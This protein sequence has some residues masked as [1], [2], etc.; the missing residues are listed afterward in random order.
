MATNRKPS[1]KS[2]SETVD[3]QRRRALLIVGYLQ[4]L[5]LPSMFNRELTEQDYGVWQKILAHYPINSIDYAFDNWGRNG[6][7]WPKVANI[8]ELIAAWFLSN[9]E[10]FKCCENCDFGWVRVFE[11]RTDGGKRVDPKVGAVKRCQCLVDWIAKKSQRQEIA[12]GAVERSSS[13]GT[14]ETASPEM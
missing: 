3:E 5:A 11:G 10:D 6:K 7:Q 2:Q 13:L 4:S 12:H 8:L 14:K 1:G 9:E